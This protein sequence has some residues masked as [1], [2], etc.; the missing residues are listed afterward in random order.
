[1]PTMPHCNT[2]KCIT[3]T[4]TSDTRFHLDTYRKP[5]PHF[6]IIFFSNLF[7]VGEAVIRDWLL[8]IASR[9]KSDF[10]SKKFYQKPP[11]QNNASVGKL[12]AQKKDTAIWN[13]N[14]IKPSLPNP[15][16][17]EKI[18]LNFY[19]HSSLWCL[20]RFYEGLKG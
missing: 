10:F 8:W 7:I 16:R 15:R 9:R 19:F 3:S 20:K 12:M 11:L 1:M 5:L 6:T 18:K 13:K 4:Q 2:D 17:R 14:S